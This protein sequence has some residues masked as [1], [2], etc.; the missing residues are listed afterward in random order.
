M[1]KRR[2][3]VVVLA[4]GRGSRF[5]GPGHKLEQQLDG[6]PG[7]DTLLARSLRHAIATQLP[8]V[9]VTTPALAPAVHKLVAARDVVTLSERDAQ[10]M[11]HSI[12]AGVSATGDADGWLILPADMPL[13]QPATIMAVAHG[14]ERY[15]VCYAQYRGIQGHPVGFG[16][17]LYSELMALQGDEGARRIVARYAAQ[18][19]AVDDPGVHVDVDTEE[20]LARLTA[21]TR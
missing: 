6:M 19:I 14:L 21:N 13:V 18:P 2:P 11:G 16:T 4:A 7:A 8:V 15:P 1:T 12:V 17:E 3:A 20:D 10:G 5:R 9:V